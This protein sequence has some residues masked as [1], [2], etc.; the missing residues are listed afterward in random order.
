MF[1][2]ERKHIVGPTDYKFACAETLQC[3]QSPGLLSIERSQ[4]A[5]TSSKN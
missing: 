5:P 3:M 1:E 2:E 4:S